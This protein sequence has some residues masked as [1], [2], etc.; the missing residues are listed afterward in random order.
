MQNNT[1]HIGQLVSTILMRKQD[2]LLLTDS[3]TVDPVN[4]SSKLLKAE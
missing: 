4:L 2:H 1:T 3:T